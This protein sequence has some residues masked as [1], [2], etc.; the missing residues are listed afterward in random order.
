VDDPGESLRQV[1]AGTNV[2]CPRCGYNLRGSSGEVCPECGLALSPEILVVV[3]APAPTR[4]YRL[5]QGGAV[6]SA[7]IGVGNLMVH[8]HRYAT[9]AEWRSRAAMTLAAVLGVGVAAAWILARDRIQSRP[10][11]IQARAASL[12][13]TIAALVTLTAISI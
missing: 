11:H 8:A 7:A 5:A 12:V 9:P 1:L 4:A 3:T 6:M 13:W 2:A 10:G